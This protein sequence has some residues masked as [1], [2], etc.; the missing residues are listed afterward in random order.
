MVLCWGPTIL[1]S[2]AQWWTIGR[3]II[4]KT[5]WQ[6]RRRASRGRWRFL[7]AWPVWE[8]VWEEG[9]LGLG[10]GR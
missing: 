2:R 10:L 9:T 4:N 1:I 8:R 6:N 5:R 7:P 3:H